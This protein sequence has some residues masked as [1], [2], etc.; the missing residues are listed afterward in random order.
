MIFPTRADTGPI[1]VKEAV[2]AGVPVVGSSVGGIPDYIVPE[3]NGILFSSGNLAEC[4]NA[5]RTACVH[6]WFSRGLVDAAT[7]AAKRDYLSSVRMGQGFWLVYQ[8]ALKQSSSACA[9]DCFLPGNP[10]SIKQ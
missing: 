1:A 10:L 5:I 8:E 6:P 7:L 2:V 9:E 3:K 4:L